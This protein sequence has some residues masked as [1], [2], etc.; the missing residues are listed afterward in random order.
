MSVESAIEYAQSIVDQGHRNSLAEALL[1][2]AVE[3]DRYLEIL[4]RVR[5]GTFNIER[6]AIETNFG[7]IP[8]VAMAALRKQ[9]EAAIQVAPEP[10]QPQSASDPPQ[11][12]DEPY[13]GD[14]WWAKI[15][16]EY[17]PY[18]RPRVG[19]WKITRL[20]EP[21]GI[22]WVIERPHPSGERGMIERRPITYLREV[23]LKDVDRG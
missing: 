6:A 7:M 16:A 4:H 9:I 18:D 20:N 17:D 19:E 14:E 11:W 23:G 12:Y 15:K 1:E 5:E 3:R 21:E 22:V 8:I 2:V 10:E 13:D